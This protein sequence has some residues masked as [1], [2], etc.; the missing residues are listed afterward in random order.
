MSPR[1]PSK[2]RVSDVSYEVSHDSSSSEEEEATEEQTILFQKKYIVFE[3]SLRSLFN[4]I[5]CRSCGLY[6][7]DVKEFI[8]GSLLHVKL[9]CLNSHLV[10]DWKSQHMFGKVGAGN[11]LASA[12]ILFSGNTFNRISQFAEFLGVPF[13]GKTTFYNMQSSIL[14]P[15]I[16]QEYLLQQEAIL[17]SLPSEGVRLSGDGR[18]DSPGYSAKYCTYSLMDMSSNKIVTSNVVQV[19]EASS[20]VTMEPLGF[21]RSVDYILSKEIK[22]NI[23]A[24]DRHPSITS[25]MKKDYK[26]IEHQH[27]VWHVVKSVKKKL[28]AKSK[29]KDC[30]DLLPWLP[31]ISNHLWWSAATCEGDPDLLVEK[32]TSVT[33][34][35][36][37]VHQWATGEKFLQCAHQPLSVEEE[38]SKPWLESESPAHVALNEVVFNQRLLKDIRKL[39]KCCHTGQ[40]EVF[41]GA[42]LKYCPKRLAFDMPQMQSRTQLAII[43]HNCNT[44]REQAVVK[45]KKSDQGEKRYTLAYSKATKKYVVK[46]VYEKKSYDFAFKLMK[47]VVLHKMGKLDVDPLQMRDLPKRISSLEKPDKDDAIK[48]FKSRFSKASAS[49][50]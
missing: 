49:N 4:Q 24:T 2:D 39:S 22:I 44:G 10:L 47:N 45:K 41:H 18:C 15:I 5:P 7:D 38:A 37:N 20:S 33:F 34:H 42:L 50:E 40:L 23:I 32:W 9:F 12:A 36:T 17:N 27:D 30:V 35:I 8:T 13:I 3:D 19:T 16:N 48:S 21:R 25:I 43:D 26:S 31:A 11:I 14:N 46:P 1:H 6:A 28:I 29:F